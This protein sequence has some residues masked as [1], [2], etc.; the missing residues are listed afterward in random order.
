MNHHH[1]HIF[2]G[3]IDEYKIPKDWNTSVIFNCFKNKGEATDRL[4][5][6][7][8]KSSAYNNSHMDLFLHSLDST[9]RTIMKNK[10]LS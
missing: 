7:I 5:A 2:N 4:L 8:T 1:H 6:I 10:K 3:I 9:F